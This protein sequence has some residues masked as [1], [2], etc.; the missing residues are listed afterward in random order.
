[1]RVAPEAHCPTGIQSPPLA[2][3]FQTSLAASI[4]HFVL[5]LKL[6]QVKLYDKWSSHRTQQNCT[7]ETWSS[8]AQLK[9]V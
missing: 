3:G 6:R 8:V 1:M 5:Q 7:P 9:S 2:P 4:E